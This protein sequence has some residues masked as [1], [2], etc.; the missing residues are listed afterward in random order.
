[1]APGIG[2]YVVIEVRP[3]GQAFD[4]HGFNLVIICMRF[5]Q[6][7][8]MRQIP[9]MQ[10]LIALQ[11]ETPSTGAISEAYV[12]LLGKETLLRLDQWRPARMNDPDARIVECGKFF[13]GFVI[14][15]AGNHNVLIANRQRR[16]DHLDEGI[17]KFDTV[18]DNS[19]TGYQNLAHVHHPVRCSPWTGRRIALSIP[20]GS[21]Q[22][23]GIDN[24]TS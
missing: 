5:H 20:L 24:L 18:A 2:C 7:A 14:A 8:Q 11:I 1:M 3:E 10:N 16:T 15:V 21:I 19:Q 22:N 9:F 23:L 6:F 13:Q 12:G 17:V 4:Q